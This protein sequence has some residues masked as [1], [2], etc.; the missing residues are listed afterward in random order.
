M[1][2]RSALLVLGTLLLTSATAEAAERIVFAGGHEMLVK[3]VKGVSEHE[4]EITLLEGGIIRLPRSAIQDRAMVDPIEA[5]KEWKARQKG[6]TVTSNGVD[7]SSLSW[8]KKMRLLS[9]VEAPIDTGTEPEATLLQNRRGYSAPPRPGSVSNIA[10]YGTTAPSDLSP[11]IFTG[12]RDLRTAPIEEAVRPHRSGSGGS[13]ISS[14]PTL[15]TAS[16]DKTGERVS[17]KSGKAPG[18]EERKR[19]KKN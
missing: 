16:L 15:G 13:R 10:P 4:L 3:E 5:M 14:G 9:S 8:E 7:A 18:A 19:S 6:Q 11:S 1:K 2:T 12:K 17:H